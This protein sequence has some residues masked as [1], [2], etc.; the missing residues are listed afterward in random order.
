MNMDQRK[1]KKHAEM[2]L[3][4]KRRSVN[5]AVEGHGNG[6]VTFATKIIRGT[7]QGVNMRMSV[8]LVQVMF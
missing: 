3:K 5:A 2:E 1:E 6:M 7:L 8:C 4:K